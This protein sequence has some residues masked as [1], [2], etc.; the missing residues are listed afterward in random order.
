MYSSW[1]YRYVASVNQALELSLFPLKINIQSF[2]L[3]I[4]SKKKAVKLKPTFVKEE[5]ELAWE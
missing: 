5:W 1:R 4:I 2:L 3:K